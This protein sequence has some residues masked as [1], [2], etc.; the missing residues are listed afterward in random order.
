[1]LVSLIAAVAE[2]GVIGRDNQLPW[3]IRDDM[4]FFVEKTRGHSVVTGRRNY[5]AM[6]RALPGRRN[7][8]VSRNA[9]LVLPD[10]VT[11]TSIEQ[12]LRLAQ[13]EGEQEAFVI[14]GAEIYRLAL[15]YAHR[16]YRTRVLARVRG[17]VRFPAFDESEFSTEEL[18]R[19]EQGGQNEHPFVIELLLRQGAP[20]SFLP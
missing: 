9:G 20:A 3:R 4:R 18:R 7:I 13:T 5:D 10:A 6:G 15:P 8:V 16:I 17:E 12:A 2:N 11:V 19:G 1:M 14:G